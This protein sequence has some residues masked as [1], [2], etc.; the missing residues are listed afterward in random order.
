MI[1]LVFFYYIMTSVLFEIDYFI[2]AFN[3]RDVYRKNSRVS[4]K[5]ASWLSQ[6]KN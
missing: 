5:Y 6:A 2:E 1:C 4:D 3:D